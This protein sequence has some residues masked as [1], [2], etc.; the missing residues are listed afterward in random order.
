M[1]KK[2]NLSLYRETFLKKTHY[3]ARDGKQV[4]IPV[5]YHEK[6]LKIVQLICSNRVNISDLLCNM[7]EEHFRVHGEELKALYE[8]ALLKNMEL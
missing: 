4:Y 6:M 5:V 1:E 2:D 8:E 3:T 7:L